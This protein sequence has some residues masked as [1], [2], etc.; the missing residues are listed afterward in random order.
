MR[1]SSCN[2]DKLVGPVAGKFSQDMVL[3]FNQIYRLLIAFYHTKGN[4]ISVKT[5]ELNNHCSFFTRNFIQWS[6][7]VKS[8]HC[9]RTKIARETE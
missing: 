6:R 1:T 2:G 4:P 7:G 8:H 3:Y 9:S 5:N